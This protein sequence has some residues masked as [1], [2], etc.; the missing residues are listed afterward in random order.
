MISKTSQNLNFSGK[1]FDGKKYNSRTKIIK[2][3]SSRETSN[4]NSKSS[5]HTSLPKVVIVGRPNV[6]KSSLFNRI[7]GK[8]TSV[9]Y[10]YPG[11]TRDRVYRQVSWNG[12]E[13]IL[14]D[15]GGIELESTCKPLKIDSANKR[16]VY[17]KNNLPI[18][19][20]KQALAA[21]EKAMCCW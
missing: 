8:K 9:V 15:T 19:I 7:T 17:S 1:F 5:S 21:V 12:K 16:V 20:E 10:E 4:F 11:V 2:C 6:G 3:C 18:A 13:F 14:V